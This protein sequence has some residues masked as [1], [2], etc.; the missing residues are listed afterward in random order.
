MGYAGNRKAKLPQW[1]GRDKPGGMGQS[2]QEAIGDQQDAEDRLLKGGVSARFAHTCPE[3]ALSLAGADR[4]TDRAPVETAD[5]YRARLVQAPARNVWIG[6]R[7]GISDVFSPYG[8][9]ADS[10]NTD[11]PTTLGTVHVLHDYQTA[12]DG[13][14]FWSRVFVLLDSTAVQAAGWDI[15]GSWDSAGTWDD[16]GLW[17]I[18]GLGTAELGYFRREIRKRKSIIAYP[19]VI[20][21]CLDGEVW[22]TPGTWGEVL[23]ENLLINSEEF[24]L[25]TPTGATVAA[26]AL[27][28]PFAI[29]M[30]AD[31]LS[32]DAANSTHALLLST[33]TYVAGATYTFSVYAKAIAGSANWLVLATYPGAQGAWFNLNAGTVGTAISCSAAISAVGGGWYRCSITFPWVAGPEQLSVFSANADASIV[34]AGRNN[35]RFALWGAQLSETSAPIAYVR[36]QGVIVGGDNP[37]WDTTATIVYLVLGH[38][39]GEESW[40]GGTD[41]NW[42]SVGTWDDFES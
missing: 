25:A 10:P 41:G 2:F 20:V 7:Q 21:V 15:D 5:E 30:R 29:S 34:F 13:G 16:G 3:D 40:L 39:W 31:I 35:Q 11:A 33:P 37:T 6:T 22:D 42:D 24:D 26:D 8:F 12:W 28:D 18:D 23:A 27:A 32:E 4:V 9:V 1:L 14:E 36:A 38:V 19:V 17:D